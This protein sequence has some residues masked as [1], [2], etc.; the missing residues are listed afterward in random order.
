[1]SPNGGSRH[2]P[3]AAAS[4]PS[5]GAEAEM[6]MDLRRAAG[7]RPPGTWCAS[8]LCARSWMSSS[9]SSKAASRRRSLMALASRPDAESDLP[10]TTVTISHR[11]P[12]Q[13][14][15]NIVAAPGRG[16]RLAPLRRGRPLRELGRAA[17]VVPQVELRELALEA[18]AAQG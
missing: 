9:E 10:S 18:W 15:S 3:L 16:Q 8:A 2:H 11:C 14:L 7:A 13:N 17:R 5:A 12:T 1:M 6:T 4:A